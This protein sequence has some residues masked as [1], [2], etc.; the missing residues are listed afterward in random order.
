MPLW[1]PRFGLYICYGLILAVNFVYHMLD[2]FPQWDKWGGE[3]CLS[4]FLIVS[5][6]PWELFGT[7]VCSE[8]ETK[9][10][11][12]N[13]EDT[14]FLREKLSLAQSRSKKP[15]PTTVGFHQHFHS[16][17]RTRY[18]SNAH[19]YKSNS[20]TVYPKTSYNHPVQSLPRLGHSLISQIEKRKEINALLECF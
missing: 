8:L 7:G 2:L 4:I 12:K 9:Q 13:E 17:G 16:T 3:L 11:R 19:R 10:L 18:K 5:E 1:L 6:H 20:Q 15:R 14:V